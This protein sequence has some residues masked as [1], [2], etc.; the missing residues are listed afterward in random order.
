MKIQIQDIEKERL[1][2]DSRDIDRSENLE[3]LPTF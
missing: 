2:K 3:D 1:S